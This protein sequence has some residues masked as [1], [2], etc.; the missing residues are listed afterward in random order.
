MN[1]KKTIKLLV[2]TIC[3]ICLLVGTVSCSQNINDND[4]S[5][6][7]PNVGQVSEKP[8]SEEST[9]PK[10]PSPVPTVAP[11][12]FQNDMEYLKSKG[13]TLEVLSADSSITSESF[14]SLLV[15][16]YEAIGGKIDTALLN[17]KGASEV[18]KKLA[19]IGTY[20][21]Y[22]V[23]DSSQTS[24]QEYGSS[25]YWLLKI[26]DTIQKRLYSWDGSIVTPQDLLMRINVSTILHTWSEEITEVKAYTIQ[27]LLKEVPPSD[28]SL[29]KLLAAEMLVTAY[30]ENF[31][32]LPYSN[33][34]KPV[35]TDNIPAWKAN[36]FFF[37]SE[38][39]EFEP[40][41]T[42]TW[43]EMGSLAAQT[44]DA[45]IRVSL[46]LEEKKTPYGAIISTLAYMMRAYND[47]PKNPIKE[48]I[49]LNERPYDWYIYQLDTGEYGDVNC[50][51]S[52]IEMSMKYQGLTEIPTTEELRKEYPSDGLGWND[53]YAENVMRENGLKFTDSWEITLEAMTNALNDGNILHVMYRDPTS[54]EGHA[55]IIKGYWNTGETTKFI[56]SDP[57]QNMIGPFGYPEYVVDANIIM[58]NMRQHVPRYFIIPK[59]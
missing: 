8:A 42:G 26:Q 46:K 4:S 9:S 27:D 54:E 57:N 12:L 2:I 11:T 15:E 5:K 23:D 40:N 16:F 32:K 56:V 10:E 25:A 38:T 24:E 33:A 13:L 17:P 18:V 44:Y 41:N 30:E 58:E 14:L 6:G 52:C 3:I 36:Q 45:Q 48:E 50:M 29:T 47:W 53:V 20:D 39:G 22:F 35:D 51:P 21:S 28:T 59:N 49:V 34:T 55:V 1:T 31:G 7:T 43:E 37:W 19:F